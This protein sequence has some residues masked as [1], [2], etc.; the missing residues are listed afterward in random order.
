MKA[1]L[2]IAALIFSGFAAAGQG[3]QRDTAKKAPVERS[4]PDTG[5]ALP[6][7]ALLAGVTVYGSKKIVTAS[8]DGFTY[9]ADNDV[10]AA[11]ATAADLFRKIPMLSVDQNGNPILRGSTNIRV[12]IDDKPSEI[13]AP[14]V[15]DAL[16]QL[17]A[18]D[19]VRVEVILNPSAKYDAEGTDGVINIVTRKGRLNAVNGSLRTRIG[20]RNQQFTPDLN[21]RNGNWVF[22]NNGGV[23]R[24]NGQMGRALSR[25]EFSAGDKSRLLQNSEE[26]DHGN[27]FYY[28]TNIQ[29]IFDDLHSLSAGY[30]YRNYRDQEN[31]TMD[32]RYAR[33]DTLV[34]AFTRNTDERSGNGIHTFNLGYN[35]KSRNRRREYS[36]LATYFLQ[37]G[38][39]DYD[40]DQ[41][42][43]Q[44][45]DY[46][47]LFRS[48]Q[49]NS[50]L[51]AQVD[52]SHSINE[53]VS[54]D[55]G[56]KSMFREYR[57]RND[58]TIYDPPS[59]SFAEDAERSSQFDYRRNIY[60]FYSD[61][62]L[63]W[64]HWQVRAGGRYE[65]TVL[66]TGFKG[67]PLS[68]PDYR[69]FVPSVVITRT[70]GEKH[71]LKGSYGQ[72]ILRPYLNQLNPGVINYDSFNIQTGN[73]YLS[74]EITHRY[75][76]GYTL[77]A[78]QVFV[79]T[80]LYYNFTGNAIE[81][82]R[83]PLS[84][85]VFLNTYRNLGRKEMLGLSSSLTWKWRQKLSFTTT[86][87]FIH[88]YLKSI[89]LQQRNEG[90]QLMSNFN[91]SY[92]PGKGY[93]IEA[94]GNLSTN[95]ITLQGRRDVWKYYG[96]SLNKK[97]YK[98]KAAV[99]LRLENLLS[100]A[101]QDMHTFS[102]SSQ[103]SQVQ[104]NRYQNHYLWLS[105]SWKL[106][107]KEVKAPTL[108]QDSPGDN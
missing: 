84:N 93:S 13:Y 32:S 98:D 17:S 38:F 77:S 95:D 19:I 4:R 34:S 61:L 10:I 22:T 103:F 69:N 106:G 104:T 86:L 36:L 23:S 80:S 87:N 74:P 83:L 92:T 47:E 57:N 59:G 15:A 107:K 31:S 66:R 79:A 24:Y 26:K 45:P 85:G 35:A 56:A 49:F 33:N 8:A 30:R 82:V 73:P 53:K 29:Y 96:L 28:G 99:S 64:Q 78:G 2:Y 97:F 65:Q 91:F 40:L 1:F 39:D 63:R 41:Q 44:S 88:W 21:I 11:G 70:F 108:R 6:D 27:I 37:H 9:Q 14:T 18:E 50:D 51:S 46:Q 7:T 5:K 68:I 72:R 42:S 25:E 90:L 81:Q 52:Y 75:E 89:A 12:T 60:A 16:K 3:S 67:M 71:T 100:P 101:R 54:W 20:N 55:A 105:V 94:T 62:S 76:I 102:A 43:G 48:R 58:Y